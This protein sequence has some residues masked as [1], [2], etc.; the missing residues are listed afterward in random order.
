[1]RPSTSR[2]LIGLV[3]HRR[4]RLANGIARVESPPRLRESTCHSRLKARTA[5]R[6]ARFDRA[7]SLLMALAAFASG[8]SLRISDP[9]LPQ[10]AADFGT[11]V[12]AASAIV[13]AYAIPYGLTQA[14]AGVIGDRLGKCQAVAA[15]CALSCAAGAAVRGRAIAAAA[16]ARAPHLRRP[17]PP[18]SCR[19]AWP[20]SATS[21]PMSGGRPV[22]ARFLA[23][24]MCGMIAGQIAGGVIGDHFGWRTVFVVLAAVFAA[25]G[26]RA[27]QPVPRQSV[28]PADR[29][30]DAARGPA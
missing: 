13:T 24:Q 15:A 14:F 12:G 3:D 2:G 5:E 17:A 22:L 9:L 11:G 10:V 20:M 28:D 26:A 23:G 1:M 4:F 19:S 30:R 7:S 21:C 25:A 27:G 29:A 18:S 6:T 16:R 8:F